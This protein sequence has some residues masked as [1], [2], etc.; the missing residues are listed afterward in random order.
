MTVLTVLPRRTGWST[1][2]L[3][4]LFEKVKEVGYP[5]ALPLSVFLGSGV[6]PRDSRD[7]NFNQLGADLSKY[8]LVRKGDLVFNRL[9]TWQGG[10]G[11][12]SYVGIVSPAYIVCRPTERVDARFVH[13]QLLSSPYLGELTRISK[14]MPPS[15]FDILWD[16]LKSLRLSVPPLATQ[17]AIA[18][19][20]VDKTAV[21]DALIEKK[22]KLLDL[23]AEERAALI[24][25]AVT[26]GLDPTVPMKDS[27]IPWIGQIPAHW[28][29]RP[30]RYLI[31]SK[32]PIMYGIVLPGEHIKD[33][34]PIVKANNCRPGRL[35]L[36]KMKRTSK[37][38]ESKYKRSR[39]KKGDIV[40]AIRG[41]VGSTEI[42]P[43][44]LEGVNLTQD[45]A[46]LSSSVKIRSRWLWYL[47]QSKFFKGFIQTRITGATVKGL[48]IWDLA[49]TPLPD[50]P[51]KEQEKIEA[52]LDKQL[53]SFDSTIFR[54]E[55]SI[56]HFK[57]YRQAL[58]TAA[59]TGQ[60]DIEAAA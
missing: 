30:A 54:I 43:E 49:R 52:W 29:I 8:Q 58:I 31:D 46:R 26:K 59:V 4:W 57:E 15:Q 60:L 50:I 40:I 9:R 19:Y 37:E 5:E 41:S 17:K 36:E 39:L 2:R 56:K 18:D 22:R 21:I 10:F 3:D 45:A 16:D 27:G 23:L 48:N 6:V 12:S 42:V 1:T 13:Y 32:R 55:Q 24:N 7:D 35:R 38:I 44:E 34:V 53:E 20:L 28:N 33:G 14:F 47:T 51:L 11:A 25:Q